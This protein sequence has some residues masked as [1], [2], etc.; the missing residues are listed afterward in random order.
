M[1][2]RRARMILWMILC[3][4]TM[5]TMGTCRHGFGVQSSRRIA[6]SSTAFVVQ[7]LNLGPIK[8][9]WYGSRKKQR[10]ACCV[11]QVLAAAASGC[12]DEDNDEAWTEDGD[13][14]FEGEDFG[15]RP[16][17][18]QIGRKTIGVDYGLRRTGCCVSVG[19]APRP[20]P[21]IMHKNEV[22]IACWIPRSNNDVEEI[23][24]SPCL[25]VFIYTYM[26]MHMHM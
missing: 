9:F 13:G 21:L 24:H 2:H 10:P 11:A 12:G 17:V 15:S 25:C 23:G 22:R 14:Y 6:P 20:L 8:A 1:P 3:T 26:G 16:A 4:T 18:S 5:G 19:Y 7:S